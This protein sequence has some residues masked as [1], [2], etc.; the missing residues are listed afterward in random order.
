[1]IAPDFK[2]SRNVFLLVF[3]SACDKF[4]QNLPLEKFMPDRKLSADEKCLA[5]DLIMANALNKKITNEE[6]R[7]LLIDTWGEH[8]A[9]A[10]QAP[11]HIDDKI[12][13]AEFLIR[14]ARRQ[15][16]QSNSSV[17]TA[18]EHAMKLKSIRFIQNHSVTPE[19]VH[20]TDTDHRFE[21]VHD[22]EK[23]RHLVKEHVTKTWLADSGRIFDAEAVKQGAPRS[24]AI[25][26][27][28]MKELHSS[29]FQDR[30]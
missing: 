14:V 15:R 22:N 19:A 5:F 30:D 7:L 20:D 10:S 18:G 26:D 2:Y 29:S 6:F 17:Q 4:K 11:S 27:G 1:M 13:D 8:S 9:D 28:R 16:E 24:E 3:V 23:F 25:T 21:H 12:T